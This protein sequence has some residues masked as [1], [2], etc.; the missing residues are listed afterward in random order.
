MSGTADRDEEAEVQDRDIDLDLQAACRASLDDAVAFNDDFLAPEREKAQDYYNGE[1]YDGDKPEEA[2]DNVGRSSIVMREVADIIHQMMP[3]LMRVFAGTESAVHYE[4]TGPEDEEIAEQATDYVKKLIDSNGNE[5]AVTFHDAL[6]DAMLKKIGIFKWWEEETRHVT[7]SEYSGLDPLQLH[8]LT[9]DPEVQVL[10]QELEGEEPD[11][12]GMSSPAAP[13]P[14][15]APPAAAPGAPPI[16]PP[17]AQPGA[18][19]AGSPPGQ[20][21]VPAAP[22][23]GGAPALDAMLAMAQVPQSVPFYRVRIKR[24]RTRSVTRIAALPPEEFLIARDARSIATSSY[25]AHRSLPTVS[26]LVARGYDREQVEQYAKADPTFEMTEEEEQRN[27][28]LKEAEVDIGVDKSQ[29]RVLFVE[30]FIRYD[31]DDDGIAEL[32]RVRTVGHE[33]EIVEDDVEPE[34]PFAA[35]SPVRIPHTVIGSSIADQTSD[36]QDLKTSIFRATLDSLAQSIFPRTAVV[37]NAVNLDDVLNNEVGAIIRMQMQGAV[38]VLAE[39]FIGQQALGVVAYL[40]EVK[41]Q[42][43]GVSRASQGLDPDTLQ[44]TTRLAVNMTA[45]AAQER[46]GLIARMT[47]EVG[48][49]ALFKGLLRHIIRHQNKPR[50]V[51][52]RGKWIEIDPRWWNADMDVQVNVGLGRGTDEQRMQFLNAISA[53]QEQFVTTLGPANVFCGLRQLR[54]TYAEMVRIAGFKDVS[55]FFGEI[56]EEDVKALQQQLQAAR[57]GGDPNASLAQA[58][59]QKAQ[60]REKTELERLRLETWKARQ[61]D[62]RERDRIEADVLLRAAEIQAKYATQVDIATIRGAIERDRN[63]QQMQLQAQQAQQA[64]AEQAQAQAGQV[65]PEPSGGIN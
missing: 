58:E 36:L 22:S 5:W 2:E 9:S 20:V 43:T 57:G 1:V 46:V 26:D 59:L 28:G 53:K 49:K 41:A 60:L 13:G 8:R 64:E 10:E 63:A 19:A 3:G 15:P 32:H 23:P 65:Q 30:H 11:V 42:R 52:L 40:D 4:P 25:V 56:T 29:W 18:Q 7:E 47:A 12:G 51:K 21:P 39:P 62:D 35:F 14:A 6:H 34:A 55:R 54:A 31:A 17:G 38:Q 24:T 16:A 50:M 61:A 27:P 37:E 44:S 33:C 45:E 48:V